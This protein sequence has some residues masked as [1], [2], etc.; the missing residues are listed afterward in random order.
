VLKSRQPAT[1][2]HAA[3]CVLRFKGVL[4]QQGTTVLLS[5]VRSVIAQHDLNYLYIYTE[6]TKH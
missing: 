1:R 5:F 6:E 2:V 4:A 3:G